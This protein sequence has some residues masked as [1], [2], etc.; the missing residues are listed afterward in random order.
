MAAAP[1]IV[2]KDAKD[3]HCGRCVAKFDHHCPWLGNWNLAAHYQHVGN[4][5]IWSSPFSTSQVQHMP[6]ACAANH[7]ASE[8]AICHELSK[9][10]YIGTALNLGWTNPLNGR[11]LSRSLF[12]R[13]PLWLH[14]CNCILM[15]ILLCSCSCCCC[16]CCCCCWFWCW[17]DLLQVLDGHIDAGA[18][19]NATMRLT[20]P[21]P[22]RKSSWL[23]EV[24]AD[25]FE[26]YLACSRGWA[27]QVSCWDIW[28]CEQLTF[29]CADWM[30]L[31]LTGSFRLLPR[32]GPE[33]SLPMP[34]SEGSIVFISLEHIS[35][36]R[37][38][39]HSGRSSAVTRLHPRPF[40]QRFLSLQPFRHGSIISDGFAICEVLFV[41]CVFVQQASNCNLL[42]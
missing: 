28:D 39:C 2:L 37:E 29:K 41:C 13:L 8:V 30:C 1:S 21:N 38:V 40:P 4:F 11:D 16:C 9:P 31:K 34:L 14:T 6:R 26:I 33:F 7:Q 42:H 24:L 19:V 23:A 3:R 20:L 12:L 36:W 15:L 25:S 32:H 27:G 17:C 18:P 22:I 5:G 10:A 35:P